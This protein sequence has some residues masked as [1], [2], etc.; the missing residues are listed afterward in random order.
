MNAISNNRCGCWWTQPVAWLPMLALAFGLVGFPTRAAEAK[1]SS[2]GPT[3]DRG[4]SSRAGEAAVGLPIRAWEAPSSPEAG[5]SFELFSPPEILFDETAGA[6]VRADAAAARSVVAGTDFPLRLAGLRPEAFPLRLIGHLGDV[7]EKRGV[8]EDRTSGEIFVAGTGT[9]PGRNIE[10]HDLVA[11]SDSGPVSGVTAI[12]RLTGME[13]T[14][15]LSEGR[16][17]E[18]GRFR[19]LMEL[20]DGVTCEVGVGEPIEVDG[21]GYRVSAID[22]AELRVRVERHGPSGSASEAAWISLSDSDE[23]EP[24]EG[25]DSR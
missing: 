6:Y 10:F 22:A 1:T 11:R 15:S 9:F 5:W 7:A 14:L 13:Q 12:V 2:E 18:T 21:I 4:E 20:P 25:E 3:S 17:G 23:S 8:F 19:A 16:S 24:M